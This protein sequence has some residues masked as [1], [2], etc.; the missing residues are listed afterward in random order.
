[1]YTFFLHPL[2]IYLYNISLF[3][4]PVPFSSGDTKLILVN[5]VFS[6]LFPGCPKSWEWD[7]GHCLVPSQGA[8][9]TCYYV[10]IVAP[11]GT[12]S[13]LWYWN[14]QSEQLLIC[15]WHNIVISFPTSPSS[16]HPPIC[17]KFV[18]ANLI[19]KERGNVLEGYGV[20]YRVNGGADINKLGSKEGS[21]PTL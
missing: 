13:L 3:L 15:S 7:G 16:L 9:G 4:F 10:S 2:Y 19:G 11:T 21:R 1:M 20:A 5:L 8:L 14:C 12:I 6:L 17:Q 18:L